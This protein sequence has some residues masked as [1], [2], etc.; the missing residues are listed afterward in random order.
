MQR[1]QKIGLINKIE[2]FVKVEKYLECFIFNDFEKWPAKS[3][4]VNF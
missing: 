3:I 4:K 2:Y 1:V